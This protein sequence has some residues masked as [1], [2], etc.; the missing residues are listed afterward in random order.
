MTFTE[1]A[2]LYAITLDATFVKTTK[3]W[4]KWKVTLKYAGKAHTLNFRNGLAHVGYRAATGSKVM[5]GGEYRNVYEWRQLTWGQYQKWKNNN[6]SLGFARPI[7]PIPPTMETVLYCLA[8]DSNCY[9]NTP[10][11]PDFA[12][13]FGYDKDSIS[14]RKVWRACGKCAGKMK[15]LLGNEMFNKFLNCTEE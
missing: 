14:H 13:E 15:K 8:L 9:L 11:W 10:L 12:S 4:H 6:F 2:T 1:F 5:S 3:K 7:K